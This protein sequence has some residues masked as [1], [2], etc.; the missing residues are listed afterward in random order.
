VIG[1][2]KGKAH[3]GVAE[4]IKKLYRGFSRMNA[5]QKKSTLTTD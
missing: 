1:K 4:K 2:A 5:D 3:R